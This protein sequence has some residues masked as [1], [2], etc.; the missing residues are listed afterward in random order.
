MW[1][2]VVDLA[3]TGLSLFNKHQQRKL[4]EAK[5]QSERDRQRAQ[6]E[7]EQTM[8]HQAFNHEQTMGEQ[9]ITS[10][11]YDYSHEI[12]RSQQQHEQHI[13]N[14]IIDTKN[15]A[16]HQNNN[17]TDKVINYSVKDREKLESKV[18]KLTTNMSEINIKHMDEK[19]NSLQQLH[20]ERL[21]MVRAMYS[22]KDKSFNDAYSALTDIV[23]KVK[24]NLD[25]V[26]IGQYTQIK[27]YRQ[28]V[29]KNYNHSLQ[30]HEKIK[31]KLLILEHEL[32]K[33]NEN[34]KIREARYSQLWEIRGCANNKELIG[35]E[36]LEI[37]EIL[38]SLD[39]INRLEILILKKQEEKEC[40]EVN[41]R[42]IESIK[43]GLEN[44]EISELMHI[45]S[46]IDTA[47]SLSELE[48]L[49]HQKLIKE[50]EAV[51]LN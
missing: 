5:Y 4:D 8:Q 24:N 39:D 37:R 13:T 46:N 36:F 16:I 2:K 21:T 41:V 51:S 32:T 26:D 30:R 1:D 27:A 45:K 17:I 33:A 14:D 9:Q 28:M 35:K 44:D 19:L 3:N 7:H 12:K 11:Q 38:K 48:Q 6:H 43:I 31:E 47:R 15:H 18:D 20:D 34:L 49:R 23:H 25:N 10:K 42:D 22:V 29:E 40:S 50:R